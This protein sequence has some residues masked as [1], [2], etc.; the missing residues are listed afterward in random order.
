MLYHGGALG[1]DLTITPQEFT[2]RDIME[3]NIYNKDY[4]LPDECKQNDPELPYCQLDGL[5]EIEPTF[6]NNVNP[7]NHMNEKCPTK[8]PKYEKTEGC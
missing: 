5:Y 1:S 8:A 3:L 4:V 7:Y 6:Y 2:P